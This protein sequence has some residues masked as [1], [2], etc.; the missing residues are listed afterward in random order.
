M[1]AETDR[2]VRSV[3]AACVTDAAERAEALARWERGGRSEVPEKKDRWLT[4]A[5]AAE[6]LGVCVRTLFNYERR[7]KKKGTRRLTARRQSA[8]KIR[9]SRN[10]V[11]AFAGIG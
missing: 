5:E 1:K 10:E 9:W 8:S 6:M 11:A 2:L 3:V 7:E 4:S